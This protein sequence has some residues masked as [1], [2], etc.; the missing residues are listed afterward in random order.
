MLA[1][2]TAIGTPLNPRPRGRLRAMRK[3]RI[4]HKYSRL[5]GTRETIVLEKSSPGPGSDYRHVAFFNQD[6]VEWMPANGFTSGA[7]GCVG[8]TRLSARHQKRRTR[9]FHARRYQ[10]A[11]IHCPNSTEEATWGKNAPPQDHN[12]PDPLRTF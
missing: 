11:G 1:P 7:S 4:A 3:S 12:D 2:A 10:D 8:K 6:W 9:V 5:P